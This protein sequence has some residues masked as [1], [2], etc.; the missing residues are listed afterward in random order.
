MLK[1]ILFLKHG[2]D[3]FKISYFPNWL[4]KK[5]P[6]EFDSIDIVIEEI[7]NNYITKICPHVS[8]SDDKIHLN[9]ITNDKTSEE[10][11]SKIKRCKK[12]GYTM[13]LIDTFTNISVYGC[14][15]CINFE[16]VEN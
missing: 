2:G 4:I 1:F 14:S 12:C 13:R 15:N 3:H 7:T 5:F 10:E 16:E 6:I 11:P 8:S 9:W